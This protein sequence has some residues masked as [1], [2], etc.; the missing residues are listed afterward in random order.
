VSRVDVSLPEDRCELVTL[1]NCAD[2]NPGL[3]C[4]DCDNGYYWDGENCRTCGTDQVEC[5]ECH[6]ESTNGES[7]ITC[8]SCASGFKIEESEVTLVA[9][10]Y[11]RY[12]CDWLNSIPHCALSDMTSNTNCLQCDDHFYFNSAANE[13]QLCDTTIDGCSTCTL[14]GLTCNTCLRNYDFDNAGNCV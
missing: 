10:T 6:V 9:D 13:C 2:A 8:D 5:H 3:T 4:Q 14:N 11:T 12:T 7:W 1:T